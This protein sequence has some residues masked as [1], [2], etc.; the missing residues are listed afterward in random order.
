M[1]A[2]VLNLNKLNIN[3]HIGMVKNG[4]SDKGDYLHVIQPG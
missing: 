1:R 3:K 4:R 2:K